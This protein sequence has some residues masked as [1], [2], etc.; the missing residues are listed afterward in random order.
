[1]SQKYTAIYCRVSSVNGQKFDSQVDE[2]TRWVDLH[3]PSNVKW[4][5]DKFTGKTMNRPGMDK[6]LH[7]LESGMLGSIVVWRLDRL[8]RLASGL[9][10]LFEDLRRHKCNLISLKDSLDLSTPA[11]R[12]NANVIASVAAY[13]TE[14][15]A[16]RVKA[17][18]E[19][20]KARGKTW[21]GSKKGH[22]KGKVAGKVK[23]VMALYEKGVN[24][25]EIARVVGIS[26]P[27]VYSIL[28]EQKLNMSVSGSSG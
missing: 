10:K 18:Q 26:V 15:R 2:L 23:S 21:G 7:D 19:S 3:Q 5:K 17:G 20:A 25:N 11:G 8:G 22:R 13:E 4:Y 9:T 24:K 14:I 27:T 6:L 1:M 16:E 28:K 12:L